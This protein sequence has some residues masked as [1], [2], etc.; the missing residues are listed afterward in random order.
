VDGELKKWEGRNISGV[1]NDFFKDEYEPT[2]WDLF[3]LWEKKKQEAV[4]AADAAFN[5]G[6]G[7]W[8]TESGRSN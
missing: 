6:Q 8:P 3:H 5:N 7:V 1:L 4:G 2:I